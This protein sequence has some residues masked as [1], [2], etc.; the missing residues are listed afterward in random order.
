MKNIFWV[1]CSRRWCLLSEKHFPEWFFEQNA[2][3]FGVDL[4]SYKRP[5]ILFV[6]DDRINTTGSNANVQTPDFIADRNPAVVRTP[7][8]FGDMMDI[9]GSAGN[10]R[11]KISGGDRPVFLLN[12]RSG[13]M[14]LFSHLT[15]LG[16][17]KSIDSSPCVL[18]FTYFSSSGQVF[19]NALKS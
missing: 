19:I 13:K 12:S 5:A 1:S 8:Q 2:K 3:C 14:L 6:S 11:A 17:A 16:L 4:R 9:I 10:R 18:I 15:A 7:Q